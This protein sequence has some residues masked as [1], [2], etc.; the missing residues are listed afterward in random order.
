MR[1]GKAR[2]GRQAQRGKARRGEQARRGKQAQGGEQAWD[3]TQ[4]GP[5]MA[6]GLG[7]PRVC[8]RCGLV[9]EAVRDLAPRYW[10]R[11]RRVLRHSW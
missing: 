8:D 4:G 3:T 7:H 2:R 5:R 6:V 11:L 9:Y 10:L 1:R